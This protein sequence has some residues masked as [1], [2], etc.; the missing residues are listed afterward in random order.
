[1]KESYTEIITALDGK[2]YEESISF[3]FPF[4]SRH[5]AKCRQKQKD[6][7]YKYYTYDNKEDGKSVNICKGCGRE[8]NV[9]YH[10]P[11]DEIIKD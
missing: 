5:K 10:F 8:M 3:G 11:E 6:G 1:M 9:S 4:L 2:K 7:S